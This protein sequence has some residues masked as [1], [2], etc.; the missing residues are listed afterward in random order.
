VPG[1]GEGVRLR[2]SRRRRPS[3]PRGGSAAMGRR[4]PQPVSGEVG[5]SLRGA[6]MASLSGDKEGDWRGSVRRRGE[7]S[8][9][10][11]RERCGGGWLVRRGRSLVSACGDEF[12]TD[13]YRRYL[14]GRFNMACFFLFLLLP[15]SII[16]EIFG[17]IKNIQIRKFYF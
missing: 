4:H 6:A 5:F 17:E 1:G 10:R 15:F 12:R 14:V 13:A 9:S 16:F 8:L 7:P 3:E 11:R 2:G